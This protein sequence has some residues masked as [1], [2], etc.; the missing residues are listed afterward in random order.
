MEME[1]FKYIE[2]GG[3]DGKTESNSRFF[4]VCLGWE[5]LLIEPNPTTYGKLLQNRPHLHH[6][7]YA[8]SCSEEEAKANKTILFHALPFANAAQA[9]VT[10]NYAQHEP[11]ASVPCGP[12]KPVIQDLL[13][14]HVDFMSLDVENVE[15]MVLS[16]IDFSKIQ[17]DV[18]IV[19]N[20]NTFCTK[21]CESRDK[22]GPS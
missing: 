5:G 9:D 17:I 16:N 2:L 7:S 1:R 3:Y 4:D 6:V 13:G 10:N 21:N 12:L 18:M 11:K 20:A 14:D 15:H 22:S 19:E 8:A